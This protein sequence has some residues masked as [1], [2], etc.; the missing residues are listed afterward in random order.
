MSRYQ[1]LINFHESFSPLATDTTI[2]IILVLSLFYGKLQPDWVTE[3][4]D[5]EAAFLIAEVDQD[6]YTEIS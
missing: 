5:V 6:I 3:V 1:E 2:H 4:I